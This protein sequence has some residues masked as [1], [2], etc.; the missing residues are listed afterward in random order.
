MLIAVQAVGVESDYV[1]R[2]DPPRPVLLAPGSR[3]SS[4]FVQPS[5]TQS[6]LLREHLRRALGLDAGEHSTGTPCRCCIG[7]GG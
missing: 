6:R 1:L 3:T 2:C 4:V 7:Q 5:M